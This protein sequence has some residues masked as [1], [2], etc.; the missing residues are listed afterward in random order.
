MR[1]VWYEAIEVNPWR[2]Q[3]NDQVS[4]VYP[5]CSGQVRETMVPGAW[6]CELAEVSWDFATNILNR[7]VVGTIQPGL[8]RRLI[9]QQMAIFEET[10]SPRFQKVYSYFVTR[11]RHLDLGLLTIEE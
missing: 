1:S 9:T 10:I 7:L 2:G 8:W 3:L 11:V 4:Q 6:E 5:C